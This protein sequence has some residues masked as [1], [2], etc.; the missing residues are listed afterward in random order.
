MYIYLHN[1]PY[2]YRYNKVLFTI[3]LSVKIFPDV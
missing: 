3:L 2:I 1:M